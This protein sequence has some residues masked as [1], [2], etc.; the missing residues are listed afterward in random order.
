MSD[1]FEDCNDSEGETLQ[2]E[3]E[4]NGSRKLDESQPETSRKAEEF[5]P[6][7]TQCRPSI[8]SE[9]TLES[10]LAEAKAEIKRLH[11]KYD[12]QLLVKR[13]EELK[14]EIERLKIECQSMGRVLEK[15]IAIPTD[16][17]SQMIKDFAQLQSKLEL[18]V[19]ALEPFAKALHWIE[20]EYLRVDSH[21]PWS[22]TFK[23]EDFLMAREAFEKIKEGAE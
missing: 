14:A 22:P 19:A 3:G 17:Y 9:Q 20:N 8:N 12:H 11:D 5:M 10:Q 4:C 6:N 18:A 23:G 2:P 15:S 21:E 7:P 1:R 16:D 13:E